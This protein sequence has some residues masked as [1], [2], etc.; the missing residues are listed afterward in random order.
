MISEVA[1]YEL[2]GAIRDALGLRRGFPGDQELRE[3]MG[4]AVYCVDGTRLLARWGVEPSQQ[5]E[6]AASRTEESGSPKP[7]SSH[8]RSSG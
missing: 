6:A 5:V 7:A 8:L 2:R 1:D 3:L 4:E